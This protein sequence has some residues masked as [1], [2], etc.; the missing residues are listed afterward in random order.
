MQDIAA[1]VTHTDVITDTVM[2]EA[3]IAVMMVI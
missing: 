1:M 2:T 3:D